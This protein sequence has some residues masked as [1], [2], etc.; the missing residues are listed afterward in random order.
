VETHETDE[1]LQPRPTDFRWQ[2]YLGNAL[3][4]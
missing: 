1:V 3:G 4:N 2:F